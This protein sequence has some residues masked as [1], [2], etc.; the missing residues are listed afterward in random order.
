MNNVLSK[1][2]DKFVL[3]FIDDMLIYSRNEKG[4][5]EHLRRVLQTLRE[6]QLYTKLR[7][8]DFYKREVQ[9]LRHVIS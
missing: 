9:Y 1:F 5:E 6:H 4:H 7:K 8:C 3:V 2:L